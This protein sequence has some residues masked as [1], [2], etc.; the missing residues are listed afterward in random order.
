[1]SRK[2]VGLSVVIA[3]ISLIV[4][5]VSRNLSDFKLL[6]SIDVGSLALIL[7]VS[8]GYLIVQG[9]LYNSTLAHAN[10]SLDANE[11]VGTV[12]LTLFGNYFFPFAG[13]GFRGAYLRRVYSLPAGAYAM[14]VIGIVVVELTIYAM[15]GVL[16]CL[17][18][19]YERTWLLLSFFSLVFFF[20]MLSFWVKPSMIERFGIRGSPVAILESWYRFRKNGFVVRRLIVL[21]VLQFV[22]YAFLFFEILRSIDGQRAGMVV[23]GL[24]AALSDFGFVF[25]IAPAGF[26]TYEASIVYVAHLVGMTTASAIM[27]ILL[28]RFALLFWPLVLAPIYMPYLAGRIQKQ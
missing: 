25:K 3:V 28:A 1:M 2:V 14:M 7:F 24:F 23:A 26:G 27:V 19:G 22:V 17:K 12:V 21:T 10:I 15:F 13:F 6:L 18:I 20:G 8:L 11:A 4:W 9:V 16:V 5:Y